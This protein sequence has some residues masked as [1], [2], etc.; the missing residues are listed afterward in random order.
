MS[1]IGCVQSCSLMVRSSFMS[2]GGPGITEFPT[3]SSPAIPIAVIT[4]DAVSLNVTEMC[5]P[6]DVGAGTPVLAP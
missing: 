4:F 2:G 6:W 5:K 1:T 3:A